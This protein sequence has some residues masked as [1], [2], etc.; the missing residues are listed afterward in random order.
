MFNKAKLTNEFLLTEE[1]EVIERFGKYILYDVNDEFRAFIKEMVEKKK[2]EGNSKGLEL[3]DFKVVRALFLLLT[4]IEEE[5]PELLSDE[6]FEAICNKPTR[7]FKKIMK[8]IN[9]LTTEET[10]DYLKQIELFNKMPESS[11][12]RMFKSYEEDKSKIN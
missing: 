9:I 1:R 7:K 3:N 12:N 8:E 11:K 10:I 2:E 5:S 6:M 4:N